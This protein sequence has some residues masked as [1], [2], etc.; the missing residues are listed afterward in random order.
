MT[1]SE[2]LIKVPELENYL[3]YM[4]EE[5]KTRCTIKTYPPKTII[6]QKDAELNYFGIVCEGSSPGYQV[7]LKMEMYL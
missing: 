6:H 2:L 7:N 1:L 5:L 4:P 3:R